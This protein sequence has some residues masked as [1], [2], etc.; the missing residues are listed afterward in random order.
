M[1]EKFELFNEMVQPGQPNDVSV[2]FEVEEPQNLY[3]VIGAVGETGSVNQ[4][5]IVYNGYETLSLDVELMPNYSITYRGDNN[6][7]IYDEKGR[8]KNIIELEIERIEMDQGN[9]NLHI[10]A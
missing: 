4:V 7:M 9:N 2:E 8:M 5:T 6:I 10:S 1:S 3:L